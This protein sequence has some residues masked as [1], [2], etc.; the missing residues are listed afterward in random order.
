MNESPYGYVLVLD[1]E[2]GEPELM[3]WDGI[4]DGELTLRGASLEEAR[5]VLR[6]FRID[7]RR[8]SAVNSMGGVS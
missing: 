4:E 8:E 3:P 7:N 2:T 6:Q 1:E 5:A